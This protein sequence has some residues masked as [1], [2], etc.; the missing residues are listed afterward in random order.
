M[1]L[2]FCW[3]NF[4]VR[5]TQWP[6]LSMLKPW[7][8]CATLSW[9][10]GE[11]CGKME[12]FYFTIMRHPIHQKFLNR[13]LMTLDSSNSPT[14][15]TVLTWLQVTIICSQISRRTWEKNLTILT[16]KWKKWLWAGWGIC[17]RHSTRRALPNLSI[18]GKSVLR[19]KVIM[20]KN[21]GIHC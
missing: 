7:A 15:L 1:P 3:S 8:I 16:K 20:W 5:A 13:Q 19:L 21:R 14:L 10:N 17:P 11:T 6:D 9:E 12:F 4:T 2:G 18:G